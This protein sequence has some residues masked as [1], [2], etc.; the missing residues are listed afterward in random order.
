ML[1]NGI[2]V[3]FIVM[4]GYHFAMAD[5]QELIDQSVLTFGDIRMD[6]INH[7]RINAL[8]VGSRGGPRFTGP[9][10]FLLP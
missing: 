4:P 6:G 9:D 7:C 5:E 1:G 8:G 10:C 2:I 3:L